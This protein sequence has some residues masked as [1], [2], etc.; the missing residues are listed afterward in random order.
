[1]MTYRAPCEKCGKTTA[2]IWHICEDCLVKQIMNIQYRERPKCREYIL[3]LLK[4]RPELTFFKI[5]FW[6]QFDHPPIVAAGG[7]KYQARKM[8]QEER[9]SDT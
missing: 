1:M 3:R 5:A 7:L 6:D 9:K 4:E 8:L 2:L